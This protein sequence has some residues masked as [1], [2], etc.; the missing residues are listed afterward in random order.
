MDS[1]SFARTAWDEHFQPLRDA[2]LALARV[3][4]RVYWDT[5]EQALRPHFPPEVFFDLP[6]LRSAA[7]RDGQARIA[8]ASGGTR[9]VDFCIARAADESIAAM[10]SG[11]DRGDGIYR[12]WHTNVHPAHRRRG[13]YRMILAGMIGYTAALGFDTIAS[14][15]APCNN[16][17]LIAKMQA[18]FRIYGFEIDAA[19]G[20][21]L[22]LRY[23][24]NP[25]HRAAYELRCGMAT[26]TPELASE[27]FGA[28]D[29][30][31]RQFAAVRGA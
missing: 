18:G 23:F 10:F 7:E 1:W 30:L 2:G 12:M 19:V 26:L 4:A 15:H 16:A 3:E 25:Q 20:P 29:L 13:L 8:A 9:L 31:A 24:H 5:H 17:I 28:Y 6:E 14:E 21:T 22:L 11:H 27:G